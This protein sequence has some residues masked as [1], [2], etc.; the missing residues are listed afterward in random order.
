MRQV[1][2]SRVTLLCPVALTV[3]LALGLGLTGCGGGGGGSDEGIGGPFRVVA[4][5]A[6]PNGPLLPAFPSPATENQ[7]IRIEFS[8]SVDPSTLFD[9]STTNGLSSNLRLI[10]RYYTGA[11]D[12]NANP[13]VLPDATT[14]QTSTRLGGFLVWNGQTNFNATTGSFVSNGQLIPVTAAQIGIPE[15]VYQ[16][17]GNICYFVADQD[18]NPLTPE[19]FLPAALSNSNLQASQIQVD[20]QKSI[21]GL[22]SGRELENR[23]GASFNVGTADYV[24]PLVDTV[25]PTP[26]QTGVDV[27]SSITVRFTEPIGASTV[28]ATNLVV[29]ALVSGPSGPVVVTLTGTWTPTSGNTFEVIFTPQVRFPGNTVIKVTIVSGAGN[30]LDRSGNELA[31]SSVTDGNY[32]FTTGAG[33]ALA[34]NPVPPW[35]VHIITEN[36]EV[37]AIDTNEH[38]GPQY[39]DFYVP[40]N[41]KGS[42]KFPMPG[43]LLDLKIGPFIAPYFAVPGSQFN[44]IG[45]PPMQTQYTNVGLYQGNAPRPTQSPPPDIHLWAPPGIQPDLGECMLYQPYA[46]PVQPIGNF[47]FISNEEKNVVHVVNSNTYQIYK[48]IQAPDPRGLAIDPLLAFLYVSNFGGDSVSVINLAPDPNT[49]LPRGD[50]IRTIRTG[51]GPDAITVAPT[52]EDVI[53]VNRLENSASII[54]VSKLNAEDPV[55]VKVTG[56]IGPVC[57]DVCA[58]GRIPALPPFQA[59][60][61]YY[62]YFCNLGAE[63]VSVFEAGPQQI[64][65]YGRD[66]IIANQTGFPTPTSVNTDEMSA[67]TAVA[68]EP[69]QIG[70]SLTGCWVTCGDGTVKHLWATRFKISNIPNPPP[71]MIGVDYKIKTTIKVGERP[72]DIVIRDPYVV[73]NSN[74]NHSMPDLVAS[75]GARDTWQM[76]VIN[77]DGSIAVIDI[78][79]GRLLFTLPGIGARKLCAYYTN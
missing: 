29:D 42:L 26:D 6:M 46:P 58:T 20:C 7:Y 17:A 3:L 45:N 9:Q 78:A 25:E 67:G 37:A 10:N 71:S 76:Y 41:D 66:N 49:H 39:P 35:V 1:R 34:N 11:W 2:S 4:V 50:I 33:P 5:D 73:C 31:A 28:S 56:N 54:Q 32:T 57:V 40:V 72:K 18:L 48:D 69:I 21:L 19:S 60:F 23:F 8:A 43:L 47:L 68:H 14:P 77:G 13:P 79:L 61:P 30:Y 52:G 12:P 15:A 70:T 64:N 63:S 74:N 38:D 36:S 24:Y 62:A 22:K 16:V 75:R 59:F 27:N 53:V 65:G 51:S 55:R 44:N